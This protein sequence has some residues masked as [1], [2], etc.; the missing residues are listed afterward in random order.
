MIDVITAILSLNEKNSNN[1]EAVVRGEPTT[2]A[3]YNAQVDF[4]TGSDENGAAIFSETKLYT[5]AQVSAE[6]TLLINAEPLKQLRLKRTEKLKESDWMANSDVTMS[7]DWTTYR[8][9]LR[10]LPSN[11]TTSDSQSLSSDLS[12]LNWPTKPE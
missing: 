9:A 10:D 6:K 1:Y 3:E 2:E 7:A 4:V 5:W 12:N 8:Q 11:Y